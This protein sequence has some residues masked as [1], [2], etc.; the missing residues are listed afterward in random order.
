MIH[1]G[2][3]R[4][5]ERCSSERY[6]EHACFPLGRWRDLAMLLSWCHGI[7]L[8]RLGGSG[9]LRTSREAFARV[10]AFDCPG[11]TLFRTRLEPQRTCRPE[12]GV[13]ARLASCLTT[14]RSDLG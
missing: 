11:S 3:L 6:R 13:R 7:E 2:V 8:S 5:P 9:A 14:M 1:R 12:L 4:D 10:S